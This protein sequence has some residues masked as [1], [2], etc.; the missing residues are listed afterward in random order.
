MTRQHW[1][2]VVN[3]VKKGLYLELQ[4]GYFLSN[5][6]INVAVT[7]CLVLAIFELVLEFIDFILKVVYLYHI[8]IETCW[9]QFK[10]D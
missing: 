5:H 2:L 9:I 6:A 3:R 7:T 10:V 1:V 8:F 4:K